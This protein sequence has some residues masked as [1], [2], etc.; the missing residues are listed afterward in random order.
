MKPEPKRDAI[1]V[2]IEQLGAA[3]TAGDLEGVSR[4]YAFPVLFISD[5]G[6]MVIQ[7]ASQLEEIFARGREWYISQG[8][9]STRGELQEIE[10]LT[11][12]TVAANVRWPGFDSA[13][14]E[15]YSEK[16]YYLIQNI[17]DVPRICVAMTRTK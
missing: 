16:S 8:I 2:M 17:N 13:G 6:T 12:H 9:L 7:T 10:Q 4:H 3:V 5:E 15:N 14:N 1:D 11:E